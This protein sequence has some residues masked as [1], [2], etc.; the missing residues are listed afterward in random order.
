METNDELKAIN[1]KNRT[2]HYF[3]SIIKIEDFNLD[4]TILDEKSYKIILVYKIDIIT[5]FHV[6]LI[7]WMDLLEFMMEL[8]LFKK[9]LRLTLA[10]L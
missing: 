8:Q 6:G 10:F 1:F 5:M 4:N 9:Y 3:D 7:K 2:F